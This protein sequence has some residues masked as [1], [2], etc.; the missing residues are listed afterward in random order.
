VTPNAKV[1]VKV[2]STKFLELF[3]ERLDRVTR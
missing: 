2:D 3:L 1:P